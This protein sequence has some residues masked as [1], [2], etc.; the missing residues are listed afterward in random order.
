M[1]SP[2]LSAQDQQVLSSWR[3][4]PILSAELPPT[5]TVNRTV[6]LQTANSAYAFRA[7]YR[8]DRERVLQEHTAIRHAA[9]HGIPVCLPLP[10]PNGETVREDNGRVTALFL[11]ATGRQ[12]G[13]GMLSDAE[14][15]SAG[16]CLASIHKAFRDFPEEQ[17]RV[18]RFTFDTPGTLTQL[19]VLETAIAS[20]KGPAETEAA[21]LRQLAE[22][23]KWIAGTTR[24][25]EEMRFRFAALPHQA[26]HGDFQ[27]TNLF[28]DREKVSAVIDWDQFGTAP[29][30]WDIVRAL[31]LMLGL[32]TGP[33]RVFL[34]AY[35]GICPLPES[36][37]EEGAA[38][39][40]FIADHNLWVYEEFFLN[41]NERVR[42]FLDQNAWKPFAVRWRESDL[43]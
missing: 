37:L 17:T 41:G 33:C 10:L 32:A 18:K 15:A 26:V 6:L 28:F 27:E 43:R 24:Q 8:P 23:R 2:T 19:A 7:Y 5:G 35:R 20:K 30:V 21:A 25:D 12:I 29:R 34:D 11:R 3:L 16:R 42:P 38:G 22:R 9:L 40:G 4:G 1:L 14:V 36:E 13:R 31:H 39:C